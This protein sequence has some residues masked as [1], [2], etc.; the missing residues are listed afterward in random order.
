VSDRDPVF[1]SHI[2]R[3][4]F[5][6]S[7]VKLR[8]STAFHPQTDGQSEAVNKTIAMY[9]RCITGDRPRAWLDWLPWAEYCYNTSFHSALRTSP[10]QVVYGHEPPLLIPYAPDTAKT[11]TVDT[12]LKDRDLFLQDVRERLIQ[13]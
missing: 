4:L 12:L 7:R 5:A 1:T 3:D 10:F 11:N 2:W 13:A 9:L 8:M 6:L